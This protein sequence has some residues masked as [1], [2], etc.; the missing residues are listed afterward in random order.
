[1][2]MC[3]GFSLDET[4]STFRVAF[5]NLDGT[6]KA[7]AAS[8]IFGKNAMSGMLAIINASEKDYNSLSDAIYNAD[9]TAEKWLLLCRIT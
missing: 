8:M 6:Q 2:K 3:R 7:Q 9:G 5:A 4:L 1:M